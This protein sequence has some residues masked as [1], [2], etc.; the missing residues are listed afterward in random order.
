MDDHLG[1]DLCARGLL[2]EGTIGGSVRSIRRVDDAS[3]SAG[4]FRQRPIIAGPSPRRLREDHVVS[5]GGGPLRS[6]PLEK[7]G[8][9]DAIPLPPPQAWIAEA[10]LV[11]GDDHQPLGGRSWSAESVACVESSKLEGV[12][13]PPG[14]EPGRARS[15]YDRAKGATVQEGANP[16]AASRRLP[17]LR[18]E[19]PLGPASAAS[20]QTSPG[21]RHRLGS[22]SR[23]GPGCR[24]ASGAHYQ[25]AFAVRPSAPSPVGPRPSPVGHLG[26]LLSLDMPPACRYNPAP[27]H[28]GKQSAGARRREASAAR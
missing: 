25:R 21:I 23:V 6:Q 4:G 28:P 10:A 17:G 18:D 14:Q 7:P 19:A 27:C 12:Q 2:S 3:G 26:P 22:L 20:S 16:P 1:A 9:P 24:R 15:A 13:R 8:V 11:N 5:D